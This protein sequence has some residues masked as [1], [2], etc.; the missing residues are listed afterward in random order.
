MEKANQAEERIESLFDLH[1]YIM[2]VFFKDFEEVFKL[3][4]GLNFTHMKAML[5][6]RFHGKMTMSDLSRMLVIAKGSFTPVASRLIT[7]GYIQ[8]EQSA[9]DKRVY[10]LVLT[11]EGMELTTRFKNEHWAYMTEILDRLPPDEQEDYFAHVNKLNAYHKVIE[12]HR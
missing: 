11:E 5:T 12:L 4:E 7:S 1:R 9:G 6:L 10:N 8:K 2:S 3:P